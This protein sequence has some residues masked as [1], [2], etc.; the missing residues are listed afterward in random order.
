[1]NYVKYK[2]VPT[3]KALSMPQVKMNKSS[4]NVGKFLVKP[5]GVIN[6][7]IVSQTTKI[8]TKQFHGTTNRIL[9]CLRY[10]HN[11]ACVLFFRL[12]NSMSACLHLNINNNIV[13]A[14]PVVLL[15]FRSCFIER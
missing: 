6:T 4:M 13:G 14:V 3:S 12:K 5:F 2:N 10:H 7:L 11:L 1:M 9:K 8:T 15:I